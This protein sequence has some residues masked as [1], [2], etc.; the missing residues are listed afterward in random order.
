MLSLSG[1]LNLAFE[2]DKDPVAG[3]CTEHPLVCAEG[4]STVYS[5]Y[6]SSILNTPGVLTITLHTHHGKP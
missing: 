2:A 6:P 5:W 4:K 3:R 1:I